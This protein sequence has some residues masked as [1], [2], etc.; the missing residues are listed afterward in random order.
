MHLHF[1]VAGY[2]FAWLIAGPD[3]APHRPGVPARLVLLGVAIAVHATLAQ[4]MYAGIAAPDQ[5]A[6]PEFG[7][8]PRR[9]N[10]TSRPGYALRHHEPT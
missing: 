4:L 9:R 7:E 6:D 1:L 8:I 3:P 5:G 10:M 2:L